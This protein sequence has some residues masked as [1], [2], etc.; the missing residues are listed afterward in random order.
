MARINM[1][2]TR[3]KDDPP[4]LYNMLGTKDDRKTLDRQFKSAKSNFKIAIVVDMW[5]TGF[6]V[7]FLDTIYID[8][9]IQRHNL[10][11]TISR[12]NRKFQRKSKGL[13]V[14]YI[15][16]KEQLNKALKHYNGGNSGSGLDEVETSL[17]VVV[18]FL[19]LLNTELFAG[20]DT[21]GYFSGDTLAQMRCLNKAV[22]HVL[23]TK[24][25]ETQFMGY[26]KRLKAAYNICVGSDKLTQAQRDHVHFYVAVRSIIFKMTRGEAPDLMQ[27]NRKVKTLIAKALDSSGVDIVYNLGQGQRTEVDL[28][29]PEYQDKIDALPE[30]NTKIMLLLK[31]LQQQIKAYQGENRARATVFSERFEKLVDEY[32]NRGDLTEQREDIAAQLTK[33]AMETMDDLR[34]DRD[35]QHNPYYDI[36]KSM[37]AK[38]DFEYP[39]DKLVE[40]A[41]AV[42]ALVAKVSAYTDWSNRDTIKAELQFGLMELLADHDYPPDV[43]RDE[44]YAEVFEQARAG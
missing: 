7:P 38:Y 27:M 39:E 9:P 28:F 24:T 17:Q 43:D 23:R 10:I 19:A 30:P 41:D 40:L 32:N 18:E 29:S 22:E 1:V 14:D 26:V 4:D 21:S 12:V 8:K 16:I 34:A 31:L 25:I 13:V 35:N 3:H 15:G 36:L 11:Q 2:M 5:L 20:F 37:V 44:V 42:V 33:K 6:D